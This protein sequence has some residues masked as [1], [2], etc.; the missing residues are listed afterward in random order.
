MGFSIP[1]ANSILD[2]VLRGYIG[3]STSTPEIDGGNFNE[4]DIDNTP[5][6]DNGGYR[7]GHITEWLDTYHKQRGNA[8]LVLLFECR[9]RNR[10]YTFTHFGLFS[11]SSG[12][13]P[14]FW[15]ELDTPITVSQGYVP[16]IR[17]GQLVLGLDKDVLEDYY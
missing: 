10:S 7:R 13:T 14:N 8:D 5:N 16:L 4:P 9:E 1:E 12:G 2:S 15:A 6:G 3:L 17:A 11:S